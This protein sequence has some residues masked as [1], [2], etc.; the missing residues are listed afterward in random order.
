MRKVQENQ[1]E[2]IL[3]ET[4]QHSDYVDNINLLGENIN[5]VKK[6]RSFIKH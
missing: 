3:N 2:L 1:E 5:S 4:T 6:N